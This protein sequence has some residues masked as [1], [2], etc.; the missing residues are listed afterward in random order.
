MGILRA[1]S[2]VEQNANTMAGCQVTSATYAGTNITADLT[3][4]VGRDS[5]LVQIVGT[6]TCSSVYVSMD[7]GNAYHG[8]QVVITRNT[9]TVGTSIINIYSGA[10]GTGFVPG[11]EVARIGHSST[12]TGQFLN[13]TGVA[14]VAFDGIAQVWR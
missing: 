4:R 11:N 10:A 9:L 3:I 1:V 8:A 7:T 2:V 12:A 14:V 5:P 13:H 6:Q